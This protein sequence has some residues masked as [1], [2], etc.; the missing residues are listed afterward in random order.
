M[1]TREMFDIAQDRS[2]QSGYL[3][4]HICVGHG[5]AT[6]TAGYWMFQSTYL[7]YLGLLCRR[8][9]PDITFLQL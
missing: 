8:E 7:S 3:P 9:R 5:H 1:I 4:L 6:C 2:V